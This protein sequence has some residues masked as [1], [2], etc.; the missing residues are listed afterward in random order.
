MINFYTYD[1]SQ[2]KQ[3][4]TKHKGTGL[5]VLVSVKHTNIFNNLDKYILQ[6]N[7]N[8]QRDGPQSF[9]EC[10]TYIEASQIPAM[11]F[12]FRCI[13]PTNTRLCWKKS[14]LVQAAGIS[15][16]WVKCPQNQKEKMFLGDVKK[17]QTKFFFLGDVK[18]GLSLLLW[19]PLWC[20][21]HGWPDASCG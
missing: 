5:K 17:V 4:Q 14:K 13:S 6:F 12:C 8:T 3:K 11:L 7:C 16:R 15:V 10:Q 18:K 21:L 19:S 20:Y 9:G 1:P 2:Q